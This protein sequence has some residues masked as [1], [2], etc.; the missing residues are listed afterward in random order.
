MFA[1]PADGERLEEQ[2]QS[3]AGFPYSLIR[4][5]GE[6]AETAWI[7]GGKRPRKVRKS[8]KTSQKQLGRVQ[9]FVPGRSD[10]SNSDRY[11]SGGGGGGGIGKVKCQSVPTDDK[12]TDQD[13]K[14]EGI[15]RC[16]FS[17]KRGSGKMISTA[18]R[19][20]RHPL[21]ITGDASICSPPFPA[22]I[23]CQFF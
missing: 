8:T 15:G 10:N 12:R 16:T 14:L 21:K 5:A 18:L 17:T 13:L 23:F 19:D 3:P 1:A 2:Q 7:I 6:V 9:P 11:R 20:A 22:S 4:A